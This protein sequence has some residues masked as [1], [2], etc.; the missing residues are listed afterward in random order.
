M[1]EEEDEVLVFFPSGNEI[2]LADDGMYIIGNS[3]RD[4]PRFRRGSG[5]DHRTD[6]AE[7]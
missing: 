5:G 2:L 3:G 1:P 6:Q 7:P 4:N